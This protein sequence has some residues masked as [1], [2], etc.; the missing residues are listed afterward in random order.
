MQRYIKSKILKRRR[1][2]QDVL[3]VSQK[4]IKKIIDQIL[5]PSQHFMHVDLVVEVQL[6]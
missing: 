5:D 3:S 6:G 2:F 1:K 4:V